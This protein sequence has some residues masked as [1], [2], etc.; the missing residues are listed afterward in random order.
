M[1][2]D[3]L[4]KHPY[5][6]Y[7]ICVSLASVLLTGCA[8]EERFQQTT[9]I[10][11]FQKSHVEKKTEKEVTTA[12][13]LP[14]TSQEVEGSDYLLGPG[15]LLTVKVFESEDLDAE[16]RVSSR[17]II[18]LNLLG[19]VNVL[20][21]TAAEAEQLIEDLYR[22]DYLHEPHV[23]VYIKEHQ[24]KQITL[25]GAVNQPGTYEYISRRKLLDVLALGSGLTEE[26]GPLAYVTRHDPKTK[27]TKNYMVDLEDLV[28]NGNMSQNHVILGGDIIFIPESGQC[29]V[30]GAVRRPGSYPI[31]SNMTVTEAIAMAG[32]LAG[33]AD[34]D[35]IKLI[36]YMGRGKERQVVSLS[37]SDLQRGVG[38]T[39]VLLD[40]DIIFAESSAS[41]KLFSGSGF[42]IGFM[43]TG[44]TFRDPETAGGRR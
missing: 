26:A 33:W 28:K 15:D 39:L 11:Q 19:D 36:R 34:D 3:Y 25:V 43:G 41:G 44:M 16:V 18:N 20:N 17:G 24:S 12:Y 31:S 32:G 6:S 23:S 7:I 29:F 27:E 1:I 21:M 35:K 14:A 8:T 13:M 10:E 38:D 9:T 40:Q 5:L 37:Y 30:D 4:K 42:S 2:L 22:K